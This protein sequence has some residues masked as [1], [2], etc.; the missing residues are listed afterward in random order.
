MKI[1]ID[2]STITNASGDLTIVNTADDSDIIFQSDD[3]SGGVTT[4]FKL[5]GVGFT[6]VSKKFRFEI[7]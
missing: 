3:A 4:Y 5:D 1:T 2:G 6:V 7:M